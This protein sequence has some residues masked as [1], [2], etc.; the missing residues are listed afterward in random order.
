M[1]DEVGN[2]RYLSIVGATMYLAQVSRCDIL[3]AVNQL[4]RGMSE[5]S[6]AHMGVV[7]HLIRFATSMHP[8]TSSHTHR[9]GLSS[10]PSQTPTG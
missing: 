6:K 1:L 9:E 7:K 8:T 3:F 5:T 2:R 10:P 4:L